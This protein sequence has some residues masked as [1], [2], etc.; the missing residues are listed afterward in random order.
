[1]SAPRHRIVMANTAGK[2]AT[3]GTGATDATNDAADAGPF[4]VSAPWSWNSRHFM[5]RGVPRTGGVEFLLYSDSDVSGGLTITCPPYILTNCMGLPGGLHLAPVISLYMDDHHPE[6]D[7]QPMDKTDTTGWLNLTLDD[8]IACLISLVAGVRMRSGGRVR[9]FAADE[10]GAAARG[11]PEYYNHRVPDWT[12]ARRPVYPVPARFDIAG[13]SG[14]IGRYLSLRREDA[15]VLVRAARQFRDALWVADTDP[16]LAWL[17]LVSAVEVLA[18]REALKDAVES[19]LLQQT[20]PELADLLV[21]A[22]GEMHLAAVAAQLVKGVKATA[23]FL[24]CIER[25][26]PDPPQDRPEEYARVDWRWPQLRKLIGQVYGYR[27][28]R[29]HGGIPFPHPLC[30]TPMTSGAARDERPTGLAAAAGNAAWMAKD[31]PMHLHTFGYIARGCLLNWWK[32]ASLGT[33]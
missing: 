26:C 3:D 6:F 20:N 5:S 2:D 33:D 9:R 28:E 15:V 18:G 25:Y 14:W 16:E 4:D 13:L 17:F 12:A 32:A 23:R 27:S 24:S 31:L 7:V 30:D 21:A 22:G 10:T 11:V 29:L 1:M 19:D 8:E